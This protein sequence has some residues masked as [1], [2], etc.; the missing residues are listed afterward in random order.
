MTRPPT[1]APQD[2]RLQVSISIVS[3]R[4]P[5]SS[6]QTLK[7]GDWRRPVRLAVRWELTSGC[8]HMRQRECGG[9][10]RLITIYILL[11]DAEH[12]PQ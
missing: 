2:P 11:F 12:S 3:P 4:V 9:I 7:G 5:K 1:T 10:G 6:T 8:L